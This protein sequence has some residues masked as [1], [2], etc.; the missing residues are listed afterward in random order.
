M[1]SIIKVLLMKELGHQ[2]RD[3]EVVKIQKWDVCIAVD[4]YVWQSQQRCVA[5]VTIHGLDKLLLEN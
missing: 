3:F 4:S 5:T 1:I 2:I